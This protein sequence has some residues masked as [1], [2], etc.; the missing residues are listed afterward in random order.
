MAHS[1]PPNRRLATLSLA[2]LG[3]VFG[4]IGTSPLYAFRE[5]LSAAYSLRVSPL[6]VLGVLSLIFWSLVL[7]VSVKYLVFVMRADHDGEGGILALSTLVTPKNVQR[8]S[9]RYLLMLLGLFGTALL[10][11]DGVITPAIS[12]LS[13]VEGLE[14]AAPNLHPYVLPITVTILVLLFLFQRFG[15]ARI[16]AVFGPVMLLWFTTLAVL[17][18][19]QIVQEPTV[20]T[21]L[22]PFHGVRFFMQNGF[23]SFLV[24]GSVFLVVTGGEALYAD[25]GHFG[26]LPIRLAWFA[27]VLPA[28]LLNYFGQGALLLRDPDAVINPFY[29]MVPS[30]GLVPL[31]LLATLATVIASQALI[32]GAFSLS[33]QAVQLGYLPRV[34]IDHTSAREFGQVYVP[35]V[36]TLLMVSCVGLVL[37]FRTSDAL[38]AAYGVAVTLTMLITTL[39][40][41][42][43]TKDRWGWSLPLALGVSGFFVLIDL[44]FLG[45]NLFK[46]PDGG[47][48]PL[49]VAALLFVLM[50]TWKRGRTLVAQRL[51][52]GALPLETFLDALKRKAPPRVPGTAVYLFRDPERVP[53]AL[54]TNLKYNHVLHERVVILVADNVHVPRVQGAKRERVSA[55]GEGFYSVVL[56]FGFMEEMDVPKALTSILRDDLSFDPLETTY[57]LGRETLR[58]GARPASGRAA[59]LPSWQKR[60]FVLLYRNTRHAAD[61]FKLPPERVVELGVQL[62]LNP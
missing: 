52:E 7:V 58:R 4:D 10:Y 12:V 40:F 48:F 13:A 44:A 57:F 41:F 2:A 21:A 51:R 11:G 53:P 26:R 29:Q 42:V 55:H 32:S 35:L 37:T 49:V 59:H 60:L 61:Y 27:F 9:G 38:A 1:P 50:T 30:W 18:V 6:N 24:L 5:S 31:L 47:W 22:N 43:L 16:G 56:Q 54:L 19:G 20:L 33:L 14:F 28:L 8:G 15:T 23:S 39:L 3:I 36:N 62:E 25:M 46:I 34:E 45:A 17:G